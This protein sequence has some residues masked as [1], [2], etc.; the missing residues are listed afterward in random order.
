MITRGSKFF[1]AAAAVGFGAALLYGFLTGASDHG[2]V[3]AVFTDG[4]VVKSVLGPISFGWKGWVGEHIGYAV[5]MAF[6][7]VMLVL[8]IFATATRDADAEALA[9]LDG[10]DVADL[11][12]ATV[13]FGI[14]W[15]PVVAALSA[16][17][18]VVGLAFSTVLFYA[19][20]IGLVVA[21]FEWTVRAWSERATGDPALN[22]GY[23]DR[24][25]RPL[26]V[27]VGAVLI[28]A[29][30][31]LAVSR[32]LLAFSGNAAAYVI[33]AL[34]AVVFGLANL[35][36]ARPELKR[37]VIITVLVVGALAL[38]GGGIAAGVAGPHEKS[39]AGSGAVTDSAPPAAGVNTDSTGAEGY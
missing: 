3:F 25:M 18:L 7:G 28:I 38:I 2:G 26:E 34:A 17:L 35:L 4:S 6:A 14:S 32:I 9:Q 13:P 22:K 19:G 15:W 5:L 33:I 20:L 23:R 21:G 11:P 29:A 37:P 27:P 1:Y 8:G 12:P 39:A 16:G 36:A 24:L 10:L 30:I 31:G